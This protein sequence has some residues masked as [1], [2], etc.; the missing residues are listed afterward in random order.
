MNTPL[1]S[2]SCKDYADL[3]RGGSDY[4]LLDVRTDTEWLSGH[5]D[6]AVHIPLDHLPNGIE[7]L[8]PA[9]YAPLIICSERGERAQEAALILE[10]VGYTDIRFLEGGYLGYC[11]LTSDL[12][13]TKSS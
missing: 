11:E 4:F 6:E 2:I 1:L 13:T 3:R 7:D 5:M 9:K 10:K 8:V 12:S